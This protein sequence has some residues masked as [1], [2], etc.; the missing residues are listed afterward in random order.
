MDEFAKIVVQEVKDLAEAGAKFVQIDEP[1][2]LKH[3][4]DFKILEKAIE[5]ISAAKNGIELS[6]CTYFGDAAPLY[7][8]LVSLP[9]DTLALDFTY[10]PGLP[11]LIVKNGC[12]KN[13]GLGIIDGRNTKID[14]KDRVI[15]TI[16]KILPA[17][18]G[19]V[20]YIMPSCGLGDYLPRGTAFK[21]LQTLS[22]I[23]EKARQVK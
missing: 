20:V 9:V 18:K 8:K 2:I 10:S 23:T 19:E 15:A 12:E 3:P 13:L 17:V 5:K 6:L 1:A 4:N 21:K 14:D 16:V 11:D 7:K 22:E